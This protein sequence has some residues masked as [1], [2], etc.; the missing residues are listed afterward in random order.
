MGETKI[1]FKVPGEC[2]SSARRMMKEEERKRRSR[3]RSRLACTTPAITTLRTYRI[4]ARRL[5]RVYR[6]IRASE[7]R[8]YSFSYFQWIKPF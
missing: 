1:G 5:V 4:M 7:K 2:L 8:V 6:Y 3:K